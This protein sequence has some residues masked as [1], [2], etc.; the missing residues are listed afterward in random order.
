MQNR[1]LSLSQLIRGVQFELYMCWRE[2]FA[3]LLAPESPENLYILR[4]F[5][6]KL[7]NSPDWMNI[8]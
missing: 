2:Q 1:R 5:A 8:A 7:A 6:A 4:R 3:A